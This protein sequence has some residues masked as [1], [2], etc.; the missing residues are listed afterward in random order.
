MLLEL[1]K[2][3]GLPCSPHSLIRP[4][5]ACNL[6]RKGLS[7]LDIMYLGGWSDLSMVLWYTRSI[8]FDDCLERYKRVI[9]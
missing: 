9:S 8:T 4:G 5:F 1:A 3:T 7:T 6:H 2:E